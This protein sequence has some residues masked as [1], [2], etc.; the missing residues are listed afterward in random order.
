MHKKYI[1]IGL[2]HVLCSLYS[3]KRNSLD[4]KFMVFRCLKIF[5]AMRGGNSIIIKKISE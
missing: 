4:A 3:M 5:L 1:L 2:M